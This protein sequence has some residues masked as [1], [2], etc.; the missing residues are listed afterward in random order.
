MAIDVNVTSVV[1]SLWRGELVQK[2]NEHHD[3]ECT[4]LLCG[5][6]LANPLILSITDVKYRQVLQEHS[7]WGHLNPARIAVPR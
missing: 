3:I 5:L 6:G 4:P 2:N 1:D 7:F